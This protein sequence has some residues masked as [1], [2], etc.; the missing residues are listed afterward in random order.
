MEELREQDYQILALE[1][2]K[3]QAKKRAGLPKTVPES[4]GLVG[5]RANC[6]KFLQSDGV[7]SGDE[8]LAQEDE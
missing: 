4:I 3:V 6:K 8:D 7:P 1:L 5:R 2:D